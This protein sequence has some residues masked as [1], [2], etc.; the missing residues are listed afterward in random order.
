MIMQ[1]LI[2]F[3]ILSCNANGFANTFLQSYSFFLDDRV[4]DI[5][6]VS[7]FKEIV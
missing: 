7:N 6:D 3:Q 2:W 5:N 1:K 4:N